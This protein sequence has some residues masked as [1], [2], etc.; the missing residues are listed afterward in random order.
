MIQDN[1]KEILPG[2]FCLHEQKI[3]PSRKLGLLVHPLGYDDSNNPGYT[4]RID[5][6]VKN[7][8]GPLLIGAIESELPE[9]IF[10]LKNLNPKG[11]RIIYFTYHGAGMPDIG[12]YPSNSIDDFLTNLSGLF[13]PSHIKIGGAE[14]IVKEDGT[15][16]GCVSGADCILR[17]MGGFST[18]FWID[19]CWI[20]DKVLPLKE[21]LFN[22][23]DISFA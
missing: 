5:Q 9:Y 17:Y 22:I 1:L 18:S 23:R 10:W 11:P 4:G 8:E 19:Y 16:N 7:Y 14:L 3:L 21:K 20:K 6:L 12:K 13:N 2:F 15:Y